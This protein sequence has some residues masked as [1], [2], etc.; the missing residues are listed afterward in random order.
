MNFSKIYL[1]V[2]IFKLK[3]EIILFSILEK[4]I[5]WIQ[6][7]LLQLLNWKSVQSWVMS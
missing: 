4:S 7:L 3:L 2:M 6:I 5:F 1:Y